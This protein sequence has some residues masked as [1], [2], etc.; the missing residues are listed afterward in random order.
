MYRHIFRKIQHHI[1]DPFGLKT[2]CEPLLQLPDLLGRDPDAVPEADCLDVA[3][4]DEA[5][6]RAVGDGKIM[7]D[8]IDP[9]V[10]LREGAGSGGHFSAVFS[11]R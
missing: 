3:G 1:T 2:D 9:V 8:L 10:P 5:V 7:S 4:V 11:S 6:D